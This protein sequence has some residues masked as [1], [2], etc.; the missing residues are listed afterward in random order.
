MI[1]SQA[2]CLKTHK[3]MWI[4]RTTDQGQQFG[5]GEQPTQ[6]E[7]VWIAGVYSEKHRSEAIEKI[8]SFD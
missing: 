6:V 7:N 4:G 1:L 8:P 2:S 3:I 5:S